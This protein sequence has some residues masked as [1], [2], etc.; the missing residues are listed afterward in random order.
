MTQPANAPAVAKPKAAALER[1]LDKAAT[2]EERLMLYRAAEKQALSELL[3]DFVAEVKKKSWGDKVSPMLRAQIIRWALESDIDPVEELD[4]LGGTPYK[5]AKYYFR[6]LSN[7]A[8]FEGYD[9][10][11]LHDDESLEETE[12]ASRRDLRAQW[13]VPSK[14]PATLGLHREERAAAEKKPDILVRSA[15]LVILRFKNRG[16]FYGVKWCPSSANDPVGTDFHEQTALTR[17]VRK[18]ALLAVPGMAPLSAR[19]RALA[20]AQRLGPQGPGL[21]RPAIDTTGTAGPAEIAPVP[22]LRDIADGAGG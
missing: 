1:M 2:P 13:N 18:A 11:W 4:I 21:D 16:P 14:F 8:D 12:R 5:N 6:L 22:G 9:V 17:A 7:Q 20:E 3:N 10:Q 15:A 19:I